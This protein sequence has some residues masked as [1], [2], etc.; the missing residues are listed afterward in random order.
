MNQYLLPISISLAMGLVSFFLITFLD[1]TMNKGMIFDWYYQWLK[2][3]IQPLSPKLAKFLGMCPLCWGFWFTLTLFFLIYQPQLQ[4]PTWCL[5]ITLGTT[6]F[7]LIKQFLENPQ[8]TTPTPTKKKKKIKKF[9][10]KH[11]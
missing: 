6:E 4:L 10:K 8:N 1:S 5:L 11:K 2:N 7:L 9:P 3:H